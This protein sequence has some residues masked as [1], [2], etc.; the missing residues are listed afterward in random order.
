MSD[1]QDNRFDEA[2]SDVD[3]G[4]AWMYRQEGSPNP[5]T[6]LAVEWSTGV[7]RLGEAE[8]LNGVDRDGKKC[9]SSSAASCSRSG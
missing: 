6:I 8:F 7:T 3:H 9:R 5:L 4:D 2:E 1:Y